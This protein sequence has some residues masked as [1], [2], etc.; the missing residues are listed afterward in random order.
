M[1]YMVTVLGI[2]PLALNFSLHNDGDLPRY[3]PR[4]LTPLGAFVSVTIRDAKGAVV[5]QTETSKIK[6]KLDPSRDLSYLELESGYSY[7]AC[8]V[9]DDTTLVTGEYHLEFAYSNGEFQ[10]TSSAP[11]GVLAY[12]TQV[13]LHV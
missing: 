1:H 6:L 7:G 3:V 13:P 8:F 5:Y 12:Q 4:L 11:V 9:F 2:H 10:G